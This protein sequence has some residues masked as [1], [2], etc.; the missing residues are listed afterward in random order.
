MSTTTLNRNDRM[1]VALFSGSAFASD[2][3]GTKVFRKGGDPKGVLVV[4]R[5]PVFR[6]GTFRDSMGIQSTWEPLHLD[7]MKSHYDMLTAR[8]ILK[9]IP[10]R[11]GHPGWLM[12]GMEGNGKVIGWHTGLTVEE[13]EIEQGKFSFLLADYEITDPD[14]ATKEE[15]GTYRN[16]S[17]EIGE[18]TTNDEATFWPVYMGVA[19][20]D[21]SAVEGLNFSKFGAELQDPEG[22]VFHVFMDEKEA[23]PVSGAQGVPPTGQAT[24]PAAPLVPAVPPVVQQHA[25][26]TG[27]PFQFSMN[28]TLTSDFAAVQ[29]HITALEGFQR[30]T[31]EAGVENFVRSLAAPGVNKLLA[32]Q[33]DATI[34]WAKTQT[35]EQ[36]AA[37]K[38]I[39]EGAPAHPIVGQ[40][41][42]NTNLTSEG[43]GSQ[44]ASPAAGILQDYETAKAQVAM[45][46]RAGVPQAQIE[47]MPSWTKMKA[48]EPQVAAAQAQS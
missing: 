47:K 20:V 8:N 4:Q 48:L 34:V 17:S 35:P 44:Q 9:D 40:Q 27:Q 15:N 26:P 6:T 39:Q 30:E 42:G 5:K 2:K 33:L 18:Y 23:P 16:R 21:F 7:M 3:I 38:A 25:A 1:N 37:W 13:I 12:S 31:I 28:G 45:H 41:F 10:V 36:F 11:D 32:S 46:T 19:M 43:V 29:T 14:A 22:R 24:P